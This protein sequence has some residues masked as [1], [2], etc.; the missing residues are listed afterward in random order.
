MFLRS[1]CLPCVLYILS[2][3]KQ[4]GCYWTSKE[5]E[6]CLREYYQNLLRASLPPDMQFRQNDSFLSVVLGKWHK[7]LLYI[8][9]ILRLCKII[10]SFSCRSHSMNKMGRWSWIIAVCFNILWIFIL[11]DIHVSMHD[12]FICCIITNIY[13]MN[14]WELGYLPLLISDNQLEDLSWKR[15]DFLAVILEMRGDDASDK[16]VSKCVCSDMP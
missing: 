6:P 5:L 2:A 15:R 11:Y 12:F 16:T 4:S 8:R 3:W 13:K 7:H 1:A 9:L 14:T 10:Y